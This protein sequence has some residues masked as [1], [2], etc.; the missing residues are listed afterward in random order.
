LTSNDDRLGTLEFDLDPTTGYQQVVP[1]SVTYDV[2]VN[3]LTLETKK[4]DDACKD[5]A[6][7]TNDPGKDCSVDGSQYQVQFTVTPVPAPAAPLSGA[8]NVGSPSYANPGTSQVFVGASTPL[9]LSTNSTSNVGFQYRF[10]P[11]FGPPPTFNLFVLPFPFHWEWTDFAIGPR[12][13]VPL[14]AGFGSDGGYTIQY[15]AE[16]SDCGA[17]FICGVTEPRHSSHVILDTTPPVIAISQ[18]A[19]LQYAHNG[20]ITLSYNVSDGAG[21]G[22]ASVAPKMDGSATLPDG[23]GLANGQ[24]INLLTEL[25]LGTHVFTVGA[26]DHVGNAGSSTVTFSIIVT[27]SSI[28][29]DVSQFLA[30]GDIK[31]QGEA[32]SLLAKLDSA[33]NAYAAGDCQTARNVY[34]AFINEINAQS[35]NGINAAAAQIMIADAQYLMTHC[36][37]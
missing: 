23:H 34:N 29:G 6:A 32:Q 19:A 16:A 24:T 2:T 12:Q 5:V 25:S 17:I 10:I 11:D 13:N 33:G 37:N 36:P 18:P 15:S 27:P 1:G 7:A 3:G 21:S 28:E 9:T 30:S 8:L 22:V 20:T 4:L 26:A 31:N 35:G 14:G